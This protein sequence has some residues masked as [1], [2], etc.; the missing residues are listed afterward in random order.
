MVDCVN[1]AEGEEGITLLSQF[2]TC[3]C[4]KSVFSKGIWAIVAINDP[5]MVGRPNLSFMVKRLKSP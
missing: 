3:V 5:Q 2:L 4:D 1:H